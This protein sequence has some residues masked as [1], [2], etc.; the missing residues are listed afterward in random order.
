LIEKVTAGY[1]IE[2][3]TGSKTSFHSSAIEVGGI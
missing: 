1:I 2:H 3:V